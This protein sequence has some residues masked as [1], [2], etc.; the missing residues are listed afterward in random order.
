MSVHDSSVFIHDVTAKQAES[1]VLNFFEDLAGSDNIFLLLAGLDCYVVA[2]PCAGR[3]TTVVTRARHFTPIAFYSHVLPA[4]RPAFLPR[5]H[6]AIL[7]YTWLQPICRSCNINRLQPSQGI[8][9][10][11][12]KVND[13]PHPKTVRLIVNCSYMPDGPPTFLKKF[14]PFADEHLI[15]LQGYQLHCHI[16]SMLGPCPLRRQPRRLGKVQRLRGG[17]RH[18]IASA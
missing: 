11:N 16:I 12:R 3:G 15:Y 17:S 1:K 13:N 18:G 14:L 10:G 8:K 5:T 2:N 7:D 4:S 9:E 6:I